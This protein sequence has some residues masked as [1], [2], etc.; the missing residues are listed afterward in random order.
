MAPASRTFWLH[1]SF[2]Q[3]D[4]A[5]M[6][7]STGDFVRLQTVVERGYDLPAYRLFRLSAHYPATVNFT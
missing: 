6:A 2:L 1:G 4:D 3:L 7:K 5:K